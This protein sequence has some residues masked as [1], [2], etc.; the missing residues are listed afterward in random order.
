[1]IID[2]SKPVSA[3]A[4]SQRIDELAREYEGRAPGENRRQEIADEISALTLMLQQ[5]QKNS[6]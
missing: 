5:L 2:N 3:A 1:M 6:P 4:I